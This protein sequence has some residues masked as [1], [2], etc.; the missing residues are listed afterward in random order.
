MNWPVS[1]EFGQFIRVLLYNFRNNGS[2]YFSSEGGLS[3]VS[4]HS[5]TCKNQEELR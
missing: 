1:M 3:L 4:A 5:S 2:Y